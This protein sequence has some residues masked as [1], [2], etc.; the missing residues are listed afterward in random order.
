MHRCNT[1]LS[2]FDGQT[3]TNCKETGI[4]QIAIIGGIINSLVSEKH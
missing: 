2:D 1:P 3:K 4:N